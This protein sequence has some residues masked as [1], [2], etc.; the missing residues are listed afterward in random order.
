MAQEQKRSRSWL[1]FILIGVGLALVAGVAVVFF[2][3]NRPAGPGTEIPVDPSTGSPTTPGGEGEFVTVGEGTGLTITLSEGQSQPQDIVPV[4]L[5]QGVPLTDEEIQAILDRVP[6]LET[7]PG[8]V[9]DFNFPVD[10]LPPPLTGETIEEAFP[11]PDLLEPVTVSAGPLEVLRFAP[12]GEVPIAPFINVTFNQ[13]MV[14]LATLSQLAAE[15]V[16]VQVTP[17]MEGIWRW[18]GTRTLTFEFASEEIDRLPMATEYEVTIPAGTESATG[19][20]LAENVSFSFQTPPVT[21]VNYYPSSGPQHLEPVLFASFDQRIDPQAVLDTIQLTAGSVAVPV[22]LATEEE[23]KADEVVSSLVEHA[24]EGRWLAFRATRPFQPDTSISVEIG[25]GTP[26][27]EGPLQTQ[28][29]QSFGFYTYAPLLVVDHGCSWWDD[30]CPPLT[31]FYIEFNNPIDPELYD[32]SMLKI[33]PELPG[34]SVN[35][36]GNTITIRGAT[37]GRTT[38]WVTLEPTVPDVFGQTLGSE[39]RLRFRVGPAEPFLT[40]PDE[41]FVTLDPASSSPVLSLYTMNYD[42]LDVQIYAVQP[43]DWSD[44]KEY[45]REYQRTDEGRTP[46]GRLVFDETLSLDIPND[47]LTE[48]GVELEPVMDGDSGQFIVVARPPRSLFEEDRYWETVNVWV[49]VTQ[50][51]LDAFVDHSEMQVWANALSNGAPLADVRITVQTGPQSVT[52]GEDGVALLDLPP[53][54]TTYLLAQ[55]GDD[56]AMLPYSNYYWSDEAWFPR[57]TVDQLRWYVADDRQMYRPGEEVHVKGWIRVIGGGQ[58]GDVGLAGDAISDIRFS[59]I[60][61]QGNELGTGSAEVNAL[62][63]FDFA[64]TLPETVNLGYTQFIITAEGSLSGLSGST[65]YHGFQ[66]QEFRRPEFEVT[67]RNETTGP[68]FLGNEAIVAAEASY[69]AGGALPNAEVSWYLTSTPTNYQPPNWS[70]FS[71]GTWTPWWWYYEPAYGETTYSSFSSR[72]DATGNHYLKLNFDE[73]IEPRPY[74]VFAEATVFDVNR[75]AWAANTSL[76]VHPADLYVGL[77]GED[78]FVDAG[79]PLEIDLI[80]TDLDGEAVEDRPIEVRAARMEWKLEGGQWIEK[81]VDVQDCSVGSTLEPVSCTFETPM[82]GR[83]VITAQ[84]TDS[85]GRLNQSQLTRWVSGG[86]LPPARE[87]ELETVTLI[88]DKEDYAPGDLAKILVQSPIVPAE[89]LLTVSRSGILY[90]ERFEIQEGSITLEIPIEDVH[91]PN[92]HVQVDVVGAS[93]RT[94][95]EGNPLPDVPDRPAY[96]RG[97]LN[98]NIP[99]AERTLILEV[100]LLETELS[101]GE[102]TSL[103]LRLTDVKGEPVAGAELAVIVVDEAILAL[104][105]YQLSDPLA[106]FYSH[107]PSEVSSHYTRSSILLTDP[108]ELAKSLEGQLAVGNAG[109]AEDSVAE[110]GLEVLAEAPAEEEFAPA[111]TQTLELRSE[112]VEADAVGGEG[113]A[114]DTPIS[115]RSDF[116]PLATFAPEVRTNATGEARISIQLPDNLTRYRIMVVAVADGN[117]FGSA[118]AN[119]VARLPLMVRP[120]APRFLNFGDQF[121]LPIVLQNQ[122]D[123]EL[124]VDVVAD[125]SN[126]LLTEGAGFQ[127]TVPPRDRIEVRFPAASDEA[128]T[129]RFQ[130]AAASGDFADAANINLPVY[131]PATNEAFATYGVIDSG[132][133]AQPLIAP[134]DVFSQFGGLEINTSSTALQALTDAVLY[135]VGYPFDSSDQ[136]ASRILGISAL[137][138]VLTAFEADGLPEPAEIEAA[139]ERDIEQ[140]QGLQN[141]DG[142]F[143]YWRHGQESIPFTTIHSAHALEMARQKGFDVPEFM[144]TSVL[145]YLRNIENYYPYWYSQRT[146]DTLSSYALYVRDLMGDRDPDKARNLFNERGVEDLSMEAVGWLWMVMMDDGNSVSELETIRRFV[147]NR[148]VE[149]PGAANFTTY[150]DDQTYLLL[151]SN[152]RTDA[153]LLEALIRDNPDSDLIPKVVNGLLAH[154]TRGHWGSTQENTFVLLSMDRYFNIFESQTPQFVA[155]IWLGDTYAGGHTYEGYTTERHETF[156]PMNNLVDLP[157]LLGDSENLIINKQ[158]DGRLYYRLGLQYA[159]TDLNLDP[160]DMGFVIERSYEAVDDPDDVY[161]DEEGVWHIK[162]GARV[163]VRV[164]MVADNRRYHVALVD[165]LPAGLEIVNPGLAVSGSVPQDPDSSEYRYSWW[166]YWPWYQHQNLRDERVEAFTTLLWDGVYEYTYVARATTPG[167]FVVPPAKAEEMYSPEV[168]GRSGSDWVVV[169]D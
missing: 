163:R 47:T 69:F 128:G 145:D 161:Q 40:G 146:R 89:G 130:I 159:P 51:G 65:Y 76:L 127:V 70:D 149:T 49:Q 105:N 58:D 111:A 62:G 21:L 96:A 103:D 64:Y 162:A 42:R 37:Q 63:G 14:P 136:L 72:T 84:V 35:I 1:G 55:L 107:R 60:G 41:T 31:P 44:F 71:F 27:A 113:G 82:G 119:L 16:P 91:I 94:D 150:Y 137:R 158:G 57:S 7:E 138:D 23:I 144:Q 110:P 6:A 2:I 97:Q 114:A 133:I 140:L 121:E 87:V 117:K 83:Y 115:V 67:A 29:S 134:E 25:P 126:I 120:S 79:T 93:P 10:L 156:I 78:F 169:E 101:P 54:G 98:L 9:T 53:S 74:S 38:Y 12:E 46:P 77:R 30:D 141:F 143:P 11:P 92:L 116:N 34:A 36:I 66:I 123:E 160:L 33:S 102:R 148:V 45:L 167:T 106:V 166:W 124:V 153:I 26:S 104:S 99:P 75:Q 59:V 125:A 142:G 8:D 157:S 22:Q 3:L 112:A 86:E 81:E 154:R 20:A 28:F 118:E 39:Q 32:E 85:K 152:R 108:L 43:A 165:R 122:T 50:I 56:Q 5:A 17:N 135:L 4:T 129:A 18:L 15:G 109:F 48:I 13:P 68:Y 88:P 61:P 164:R 151:S 147:A 168:F 100:E 95:D 80:V 73:A 24:E 131:T 19:E 139:V 132:A 52:T 155:Q 90:T